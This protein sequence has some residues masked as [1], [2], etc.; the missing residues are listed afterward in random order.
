VPNA[1]A[2]A[3]WTALYLHGPV[4]TSPDYSSGPKTLALALGSLPGRD[5]FS[6]HTDWLGPINWSP[7]RE[8]ALVGERHGAVYVVDPA[9]ALR[10]LVD[11]ATS[12]WGWL[13]EDSV[14]TVRQITGSAGTRTVLQ[15]IQ[16]ST[17]QSSQRDLPSGVVMGDFSPDGRFMVYVEPGPQSPTRSLLLDLTSLQLRPLTPGAR[18]RGWAKD[19]RLL[20]LRGEGTERTA[21]LL[22]P[23]DLR[24]SVLMTSIRDAIASPA[25]THV[26][27]IDGGG[28]AWTSKG[29]AAPERRSGAIPIGELLSVSDSGDVVSYSRRTSRSPAPESVRTFV[30]LLTIG[31]AIAACEE[32]CSD[33]VLR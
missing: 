11:G 32:G 14:G 18:P 13:R 21:E 15:T 5:I 31:Q 26:A 28:S 27:L 16:P 23:V 8:R 17:G 9:G 19:G 3:E 4:G 24:V 29:G 33:L 20:V 2:I 25:S 1:S 10:K 30:L 22:D 7:S 12:T 6:D